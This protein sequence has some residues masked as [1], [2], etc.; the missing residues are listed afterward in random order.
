MA[1]KF[2][3]VKLRNPKVEGEKLWYGQVRHENPIMEL[4]DL[5]ITVLTAIV[6]TFA[7]QSCINS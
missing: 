2:Q 1:L 7:V 3:V 5:A 4:D 6:S